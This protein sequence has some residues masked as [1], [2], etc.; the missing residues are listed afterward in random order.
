[1]AAGR[2]LSSYPRVDE[3][4]SLRDPATGDIVQPYG[5]YGGKEPAA[6]GAERLYRVEIWPIGNRFKAGHRLR[7]RWVRGREDGPTEEARPQR[8]AVFA[9]RA[10]WLAAGG[11]P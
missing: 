1:V 7:V 8:A 10:Q 3:A 5:V 9:Y 6:I 4:R 2:L 11:R